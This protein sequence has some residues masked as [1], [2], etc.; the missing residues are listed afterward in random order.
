MKK[1]FAV[2]L[3]AASVLMLGGCQY[4]NKKPD[5]ATKVELKTDAQKEAYAIGASVSHYLDRTLKQQEKLGLK[6]DRKLILAGVK[7]GLNGKNQLS[8]KQITQS[9]Q[10][11]QAQMTKLVKDK[12]AKDAKAAKEAGEKFLKENAK[13]DGVITTKSG[14]EYKVLRKGK[15]LRPK[16]DDTVTVNYKGTLID[17]KKFDSSYDR[18]K[19]ITFPLDRVIPG[20]SEGVQLMHV[21]AKYKFFIPAKLAYGDTKAGPIPANSTLIFE[22][23]LLGIKHHQEAKNTKSH[24]SK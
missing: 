15:G 13:K 23:E 21:G 2:S 18:G 14:L 11:M 9:L 4:Q 17:G 16:A 12:E 24:S 3:L 1:Y 6:L 10:K 8:D 19:P 20:W 7:E 5:T 22:V